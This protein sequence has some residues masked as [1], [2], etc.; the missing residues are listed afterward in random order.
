VGYLIVEYWIGILDKG[1]WI[2][3]YCI[4]GYL[5]V[6]QWIVGYWIGDNG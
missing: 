6:G 1:Y 2:V 4:V 3:G 5:I